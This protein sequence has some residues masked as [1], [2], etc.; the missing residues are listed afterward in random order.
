M[1]LGRGFSPASAHHGMR[2]RQ[3]RHLARS[4]AALPSINDPRPPPNVS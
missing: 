3:L 2:S 1:I 4:M